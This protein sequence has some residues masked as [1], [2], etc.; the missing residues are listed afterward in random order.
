[1]S[2]CARCGKRDPIAPAHVFAHGRQGI[3]C[4]GGET[5]APTCYTRSSWENWPELIPA[6]D[7]T[8]DIPELRAAFCHACEANGFHATDAMFNRAL[9]RIRADARA[10]V[11]AQ[12]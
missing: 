3:Y 7:Y 9:E 5:V 1:M 6:D 10:E 8:P 12:N 2:V 4:H 11:S